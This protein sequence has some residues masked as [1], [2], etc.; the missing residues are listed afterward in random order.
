VH[1]QHI[2]CRSESITIEQPSKHARKKA[3]SQLL[4]FPSINQP[5]VK[6]TMKLFARRS[7]QAHPAI[8]K[9]GQVASAKSLSEPQKNKAIPV[10]GPAVQRMTFEQDSKFSHIPRSWRISVGVLLLAL[11]AMVLIV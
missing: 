7:R 4:S 3:V 6:Q 11:L 10:K 8:N 2:T 5:K 1:Q 9:R